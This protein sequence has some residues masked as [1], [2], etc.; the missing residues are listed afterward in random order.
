MRRMAKRSVFKIIVIAGFLIDANIDRSGA[1]LRNFLLVEDYD[2]VACRRYILQRWKVTSNHRA[3]LP[4]L[5]LR[6]VPARSLWTERL[7]DELQRYG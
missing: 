5:D 6:P 1:R 4:V 3:T 7:P 2:L